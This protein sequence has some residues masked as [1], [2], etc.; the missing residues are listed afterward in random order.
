MDFAR[1]LAPSRY[2]F[3]AMLNYIW[4]GLIVLSV[5]VG[6]CTDNLKAVA[7]KSFEMA[8]FA[9][10]KTALPL[11][12]IM[13]LW[14]GIMRLAERAGLVAALARLLRPLMVWLFPDVPADHPAMGSMLL[15]MAASI[16]GL[17]NAAT[18]L[19]LRAMKDL[20][21]LNP[22]PGTATN[23]MCTYLAINTSS[24]QLIPATAIAILAANKSSNPTAIVGTSIMATTCAAIAAVTAAKI[25]QRLPIYRL[26]PMDPVPAA[27]ATAP[28]TPAA[29]NATN[30]KAPIK[31]AAALHP[32]AWWGMLI[33]AGFLL[34]F[35]YLF[36]RL[37]FPALLGVTPAPAAVGTTTFIRIVDAIS[38][39]SIPFM[40]SAF[41]LY[42]A[43]RNVK[44]YEEFVD[45]AKEGFDVAIRILPY[46]VAILV[47]MGMFRAA[48]CID[49]ISHA[50]APMMQAV[51]FP[52]PLLPMVLMRPLS[53]SG[54]LGLFAELVQQY[55]PDSLISR[56]GGTIFG[57]TETTFYVLAVYFGSVAVKRT[58]YAL[59]AGLIA[60]TAGVIAS[61]IFCRLVF[62]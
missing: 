33:M 52:P 40:L 11:V 23:A 10:M 4:L 6:G 28:A 17:G 3:C 39:L 37:A 61:V 12:G 7:D 49:L 2:S 34:F 46:L 42:A 44:V 25:L 45:G 55:G 32:L 41:P 54:T 31:E 14:L 1:G 13:A 16:L 59:P 15:N 26:P 22:R 30:D 50:L 27:A 56:M 36:L 24:I 62:G 48:G 9:V 19:G 58:R 43:L 21:T 35:L 18:P 8:E 60:D 57:S 47:A 20:E 5:I 53:G 51:G 29:P 38:R